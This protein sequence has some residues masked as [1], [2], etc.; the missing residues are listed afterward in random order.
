MRPPPHINTVTVIYTFCP[1]HY[2]VLLP[3]ASTH[4]GGIVFVAIDFAGLRDYVR[5]NPR[6]RT[7]DAFAE[8]L[9]NSG[10]INAEVTE[11][12]ELEVSLTR[13]GNIQISLSARNDVDSAFCNNASERLASAINDPSSVSGDPQFAQVP[14]ILQ[15]ASA[16]VAAPNAAAISTNEVTD[17]ESGFNGAPF[18]KALSYFTLLLLVVTTV[19]AV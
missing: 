18:V 7:L 3:Y 2:F 1:D 10:F 5:I 19:V 6:V 12:C 15:F 4:T 8:V 17:T 14:E 9:I 13:T 16:A 11:R